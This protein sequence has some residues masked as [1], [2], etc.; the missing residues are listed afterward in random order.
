M[1][2][3][4]RR[5]C[6]TADNQS[7]DANALLVAHQRL[8]TQSAQSAQRLDRGQVII[9]LRRVGIE[10]RTPRTAIIPYLGT[11]PRRRSADTRRN[12]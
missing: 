8:S 6:L 7:L 5:Y 2:A 1:N 12:A 4:G 10:I 3:Y 11:P 9:A